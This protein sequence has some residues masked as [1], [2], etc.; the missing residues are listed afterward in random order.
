MVRRSAPASSRWVAK[1]WRSVVRMDVLVRQAGALSGAESEPLG[2]CPVFDD[3][4]PT[5]AKPAWVGHPNDHCL[6][7]PPARRTRRPPSRTT[8]QKRKPTT[9]RIYNLSGRPAVAA[10]T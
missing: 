8:A 9:P 5:Q 6:G 4:I 2:A 7:H 3:K 1:Q 10:V